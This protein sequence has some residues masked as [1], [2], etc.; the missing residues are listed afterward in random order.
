MA[1]YKCITAFRIKRGHRKIIK[2]D[3]AMPR[4][5]C[6]KRRSHCFID[7]YSSIVQQPLYFT[8]R[9][10]GLMY[11]GRDIRCLSDSWWVNLS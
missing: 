6:A 1:I 9:N 7:D 3:G 5:I 10:R 11:P 4:S 8:G 2:L